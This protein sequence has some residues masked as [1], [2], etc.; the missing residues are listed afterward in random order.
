MPRSD[1]WTS[2]SSR[3]LGNHFQ[4]FFLVAGYLR[5]N[6]KFVKFTVPGSESLKTYN[7][8]HFSQANAVRHDSYFGRRRLRIGSALW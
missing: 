1:F 2:T 4:A 6:G 5:I 8:D 3:K 7:E